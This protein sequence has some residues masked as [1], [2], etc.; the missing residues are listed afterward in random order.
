MARTRTLKQVRDEIRNRGEIDSDFVPDSELNRM[1]NVAYAD[2]YSFLVDNNPDLFIKSDSV[3]VVSGTQSYALPDDCWH[4][5]G[6][7]ALDG[8]DWYTLD[9]FNWS[10][11]NRSL[12][13]AGSNGDKFSA[14]WRD[15]GDALYFEPVPSWSGTVKVWYI[16]EPEELSADGHTIRS[17]AGWEEYV[18]LHCLIQYCGKS[19]QDHT[20]FLSQLST[21]KSNML[22]VVN[23]KS[24]DP[25]RMRDVSRESVYSN[26]LE[27]RLPRAA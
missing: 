13:G 22:N 9:V 6:I 20:L 23:R 8:S 10:E 7:D 14:R 17:Y 26:S 5:V 15:M 4:I 24:S 3:A 27:P 12:S 25:D 16:P 18:V 11:R 1:I 19:E 2:Y 21:L